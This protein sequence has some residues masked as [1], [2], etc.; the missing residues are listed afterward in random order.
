[1]TRLAEAGAALLGSALLKARGL[2]GGSLSQIVHIT[3]ADG[4]EA[5][6]KGGAAPIAEAAMLE[7]IAASGAPA[8]A[9]LAA[10]GEA[11]V[12]EAMP[13][14]G[15]LNEA[16]AGLGL[17]LAKLH[18]AKG[19]SYGWADEYSFGPVAIANGWMESWPGFWAERRLLAHCPHL[20]PAL[21]RR[22]EALAADLQ[23]R[24]PAQPPV[25]LLHGDLWGGNIL[26][27]RNRVSALI[28]PACYYGHAEVDIAMLG[29]FDRPSPAFYEA[30]GA[31]EP[32]HEE[33]VAVYRLWPALVHLRL[34]GDG[35]RPLT[36]Q[37]LSEAGA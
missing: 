21:A 10:S 11:L 12:I 16:W 36:A 32:G 7:A 15:S 9:V 24:L 17:V 22:V 28:D 29:L 34:F 2:H 35:Y 18:A 13:A 1:M 26:I 14:G 8:P 20:A 4:R 23:N 19:R 27:A 25:S 30:Y 33:R 3:L 31:L 37:L 5:I 6:V